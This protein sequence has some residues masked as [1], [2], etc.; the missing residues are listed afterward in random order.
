MAFSKSFPKTGEKYPI[1]E[2]ILLSEEEE[3]EIEQKARNF[4]KKLMQECI[5]DAKEIVSKVSLRPF[6]NVI[7][8]IAIALFEKRA[9]HEV[10][11]KERLC[12]DKFDNKY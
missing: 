1:W 3:K 7:T 8:R 6:Q 12:R 4:N 10:Y 11:W 5:D 9:S 2:E